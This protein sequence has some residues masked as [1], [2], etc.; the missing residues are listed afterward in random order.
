MMN[1]TCKGFLKSKQGLRQGDLL[2]PNLFIL[3]E[4]ILSRILKNSFEEG[5]IGNFF[6]L[7]G[8]PLILAL[9]YVDDLL[10]FTNGEKDSWEGYQGLWR[11]M[12]DGRAKRLIKRN[13]LFTCLIKSPDQ[14][15]GVSEGWPALWKDIYSK[16]SRGSYFSKKNDS[17]NAWSSSFKILEQGCKMERKIVIARRTTYP[18]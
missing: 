11:C 5:R 14:E 8:T 7:R 3:V 2:F 1:S 16:V 15:E 17:S 9:L 18:S 6:H 12:K 4:E 10:V 13:R